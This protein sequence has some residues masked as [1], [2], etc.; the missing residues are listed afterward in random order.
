M[1]TCRFLLLRGVFRR[2]FPQNY[3]ENNIMQLARYSYFFRLVG[4]TLAR[5]ASIGPMMRPA[6]MNSAAKPKMT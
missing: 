1:I 5:I 4:M 6:H 2:S 3:T